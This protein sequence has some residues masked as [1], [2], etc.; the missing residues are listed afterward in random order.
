MKAQNKR[1]ERCE[2]SG[3]ASGLVHARRPKGGVSLFVKSKCKGGTTLFYSYK[4]ALSCALE[5]YTRKGQNPETLV[6]TAYTTQRS[7]NDKTTKLPWCSRSRPHAP[8]LSFAG[9]R[10]R[11]CGCL[12]IVESKQTQHNIDVREKVL[13]H[14]LRTNTCGLCV[15]LGL[16][17]WRGF[18]WKCSPP[19]QGID[20]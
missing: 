4:E 12:T 2:Q 8:A 6:I 16:M 5:S 3:A 13:N 19:S 7:V 15:S 11:G 20:K 1:R 14:V 17:L 9:L 10:A 18:A